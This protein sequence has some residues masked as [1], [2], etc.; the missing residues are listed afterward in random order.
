[1]SVK[2]SEPASSTCECVS[3][4]LVVHV[5]RGLQ[6]FFVGTLCSNV[7]HE[8]QVKVIVVGV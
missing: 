2:F 6:Y 5:Q 3:L 8:T 7:R 1:M 4:T